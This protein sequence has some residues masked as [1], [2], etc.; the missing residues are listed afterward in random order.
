MSAQ[1]ARVS[2]SLLIA[3][4]LTAQPSA[5]QLRLN[6][7]AIRAVRGA[8]AGKIERGLP[9]ETFEKWFSR[10]VG[11]G[12]KVGWG[13]NDCGEASGDPK[14]DSERDL[15]FC[16]AATADLP[17]GRLVETYILAG[18]EK[19]GLIA[20]RYG[21]YLVVISRDKRADFV[22]TLAELADRMKANR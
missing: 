15:P 19:R 1:I 12:A 20:G 8:P 17:D 3:L 4:P 22:R 9:N 16:V 18:S 21:V 7:R 14:V 13:V 10:V 5:P 6:E 11:P 2:V